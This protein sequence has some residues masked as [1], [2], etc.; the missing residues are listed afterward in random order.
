MSLLSVSTLSIQDAA[1]GGVTVDLDAS[2]IVQVVLFIVLMA[3]L[4]P[5]LFDPMLRL[6]EEREKRIDGTKAKA[7][8]KDKASAEALTKYEE[9]MGKARV[10]GGA[11]RDEI[12][13]EGLK[14]EQ[15]LMAEVRASVAATLES[16][17]AAVGAEVEQARAKLKTEA[18][19]LGREIA[20][21]TLGREVPR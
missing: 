18:A 19:E 13:A 6:F 15:A 12:R 20:A 2:L 8:K 3:V 10:A 16:G 7:R 1:G 14:K 21:R 5:T 4:K 9:A 11:S 17:R